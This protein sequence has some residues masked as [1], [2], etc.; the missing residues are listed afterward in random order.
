MVWHDLSSGLALYPRWGAMYGANAQSEQAL[1]AAG[2]DQLPP[3][4]VVV[5]DRNFGVFSMDWEAAQRDH[6]VVVRLT[7]AR[8]Y[9]LV[10]GPIAQALDAAVV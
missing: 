5:A 8:A 7:Q 9:K 6:G 4:A 3:G 10:G 1:A 2:M